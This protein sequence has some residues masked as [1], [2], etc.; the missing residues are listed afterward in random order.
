MFLAPIAVFR[1]EQLK[2]L[3]RGVI[4]LTMVF[5][6]FPDPAGEDNDLYW[7]SQSINLL[8]IFWQVG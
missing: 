2:Q 3:F 5:S 1:Y 6:L 4:R 8:A 7:H